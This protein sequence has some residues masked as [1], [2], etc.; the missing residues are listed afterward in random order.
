[1]WF[2]PN[3]ASTTLVIYDKNDEHIKYDIMR[4]YINSLDKN[5]VGN[6]FVIIQKNHKYNPFFNKYIKK[7]N[8]D[9]NI[10]IYTVN[11][12]DNIDSI[13]FTLLQKQYENKKHNIKKYINIII[14]NCEINYYKSINIRELIFNGRFSYCNLLMIMN[15]E[16]YIKNMPYPEIRTNIDNNILFALGSN[17]NILYNQFAGMYPT[18]DIFNELIKNKKSLLITNYITNNRVSEFNHYILPNKCLI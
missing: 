1:M 12:G 15:S 17:N 4:K 3:R 11:V 13:I 18:Y 10:N 7:F 9:K 14:D 5:I 6:D 16:S 2:D 8:K